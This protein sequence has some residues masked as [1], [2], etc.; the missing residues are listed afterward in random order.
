M[1]TI[2]PWDHATGLHTRLELAVPLKDG[3]FTIIY[4]WS[5]SQLNPEKQR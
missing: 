5:V 2:T 3:E 4:V 1:T